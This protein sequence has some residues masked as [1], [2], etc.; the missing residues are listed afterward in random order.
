MSVL[1]WPSR[2]S[3][4]DAG[5]GLA[6]GSQKPQQPGTGAE[7]EPGQGISAVHTLDS[8]L[9]LGGEP[10]TTA[11]SLRVLSSAHSPLAQ[12]SSLQRP[13]EATVSPGGL[14]SCGSDIAAYS[15]AGGYVRRALLRKGR[16]LWGLVPQLLLSS[17]LLWK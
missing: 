13:H 4:R 6:L 9:Q 1:E 2:E 11:L 14:L 16:V 5:G 7:A 17:A 12:T 15:V 3:H 8:W 10:S